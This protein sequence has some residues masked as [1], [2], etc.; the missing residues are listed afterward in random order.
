MITFESVCARD[1]PDPRTVTPHVL[2]LYLTSSY[3][4]D[5]IDHQIDV[6]SKKEKGH[7]YSRYGNPTVEAVAKKIADLEVHGTGLDAH[8]I[9]MSSGMSAIHTLLLSVMKSGD[10]VLTQGNLYGGTTELLLKVGARCGIE[11]ILTDLSD[12][13]AVDDLLRSDPAIKLVYFETPSNPT[14]QCIDIAAISDVCKKYG[15]FTAIDN[16]FPTPYLQQPFR[17]GVDFII[18][19]TTKYLN[20]HGNS[21]AGVLIGCDVEFMR[22]RAWETMVLIGTNPGPLDAWLVHQGMK[23]LP[24]RMDRHCEN[25]MTLALFLEGH[26]RV[27]RVNYTGLRSHP[28]HVLAKAQMKDFGGMLSFEVKGGYDGAVEVL[29]KIKF[30]KL[31]PTLGDV[32]TLV[33]HPVS[34]SH[35][36]IDP[37]IRERNGI[38]D[39]LIRVSVG[40]EGVE[41][42]IGDLE[43]ALNQN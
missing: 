20:G 31:A 11:T 13:N 29:R 39:G 34:S 8:G 18:H 28:D 42:I 38:T 26:E 33:L 3:D 25:A 7:V 2:P 36:N 17:Y 27:S 41:D 4:F 43:Q 24:L 5:S 30:C 16:T 9:M 35:R 40:I 14:L 1:V 23:T 32:D 6:F 37:E 19:S 12:E 15:R 21:I 10:K 22:T